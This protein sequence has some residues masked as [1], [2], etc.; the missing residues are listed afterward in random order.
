M[1]PARGLALARVL[2]GA[3]APA[4]RAALAAPR[5]ATARPAV[6]WFGSTGAKRHGDGCGHGHGHEHE[7]KQLSPEEEA[8]A[9]KEAEFI[10]RL[11]NM[12][13]EAKELM[14]R[15]EFTKALSNAEH[16]C[17]LT[18]EY[19]GKAH[20]AYASALNNVG[21]VWRVCHARTLVEF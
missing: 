21:F 17:T 7:R 5:T 12:S 8:K 20:P 18:E 10:A 13:V 14:D 3:T 1:L 11:Q 15:S 4:A 9:Q 16:M 19:F 6:A 2:R